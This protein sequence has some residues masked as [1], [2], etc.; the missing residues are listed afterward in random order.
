MKKV[1]VILAIFLALILVA[2]LCCIA[3][4]YPNYERQQAWRADLNTH[5]II[6]LTEERPGTQAA[7]TTQTAQAAEQ[8]DERF[9]DE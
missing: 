5:Y 3:L 4:Y 2:A 8:N 6:A 1:A 9:S 7:Y